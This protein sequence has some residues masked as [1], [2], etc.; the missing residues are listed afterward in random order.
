MTKRCINCGRKMPKDGWKQ[1]YNCKTGEK[2]YF[3]KFCDPIFRKFGLQAE[4][5]DDK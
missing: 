3:C 5:E 4:V 2:I 1:F